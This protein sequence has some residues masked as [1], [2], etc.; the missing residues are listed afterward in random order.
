ML[1][2]YEMIFAEVMEQKGCKG[3]YELFDSVDFEIVEERCKA[4]ED[5]DLEVFNAWTE[6]MAWDL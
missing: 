6:E 5:F 2:K 3:W 4:L 1:E